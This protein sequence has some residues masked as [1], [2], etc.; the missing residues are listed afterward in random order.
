MALVIALYV[1]FYLLE[2]EGDEKIVDEEGGS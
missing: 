2:S 1:K